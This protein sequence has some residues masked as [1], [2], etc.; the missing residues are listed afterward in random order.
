MLFK[1][2]LKHPMKYSGRLLLQAS[3][4][5]FQSVL[6]AREGGVSNRH[7]RSFW[8]ARSYNLGVELLCKGLDD[9]GS[10]SAFRLGKNAIGFSHSVVGDRKLP[11]RPSHIVCNGDLPIFRF[12][13]ESML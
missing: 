3:M 7:G 8:P 6:S 9:A 4:D 2:P 11:V 10:Q 1:T 12:F 5:R 13:V